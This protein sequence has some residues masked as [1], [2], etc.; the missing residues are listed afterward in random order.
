[1]CNADEGMHPM[2]LLLSTVGPFRHG[3]RDMRRT[4]LACHEACALED[5]VY[6]QASALEERRCWRQPVH[7]AH[8][9]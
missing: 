5:A 2:L 7:S 8:Q 9:V 4:L 3:A 1:M 6:G